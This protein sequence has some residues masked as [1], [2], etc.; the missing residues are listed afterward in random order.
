MRACERSY[1]EAIRLRPHYAA[2]W[3]N[4]GLVLLNTGF[5]SQTIFTL[6]VNST[7]LE[8]PEEAEEAYRTALKHKPASADA[9]TNYGHLCRIQERWK[10]ADTLYRIA[11]KKRPHDPGLNYNLG[12][13]NEEMEKLDV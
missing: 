9:S 1:R 7:S 2:A 11:L 13:V 6:S 4:L 5:S 12:L 8:R 10:E 3:T